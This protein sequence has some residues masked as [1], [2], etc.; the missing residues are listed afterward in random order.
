MSEYPCSVCHGPA[1][2]SSGLR[3]TTMT[4]D[5]DLVCIGCASTPAV[6]QRLWPEC[7]HGWHDPWDHVTPMQVVPESECPPI[8]CEVW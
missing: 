3:L 7:P 6:H 1:V 8:R 4:D 5:G 2:S